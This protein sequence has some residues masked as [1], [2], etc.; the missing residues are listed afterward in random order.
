M[1]SIFPTSSGISSFYHRISSDRGLATSVLATIGLIAKASITSLY[2][3]SFNPIETLAAGSALALS[4]SL[5][6]R[7]Q[8]KSK[9]QISSSKTTS[10]N[11]P[12]T[13]TENSLPAKPTPPP[14]A[15]RRSR[16]SSND[17]SQPDTLRRRPSSAKPTPPPVVPRKPEPNP[18]NTGLPDDIT[19]SSPPAKPMANDPA[20]EASGATDPEVRSPSVKDLLSH[21]EE[22]SSPPESSINPSQYQSSLSKAS[23]VNTFKRDLNNVLSLRKENIQNALLIF[24]KDLREHKIKY[25][26]E[27]GLFTGD[28]RMLESLKNV[29][30]TLKFLGG[31]SYASPNSGVF[32]AAELYPLTE[33]RQFLIA[34][35]H[36][37]SEHDSF[38]RFEETDMTKKDQRDSYYEAA[39]SNFEET[40][41]RL[42][43]ESRTHLSLEYLQIISSKINGIGNNV[44][45]ESYFPAL[46]DLFYKNITKFL[47]Q[48]VI[49]ARL[50]YFVS[51]PEYRALFR[52]TRFHLTDKHIKNL[53]TI[54]P[55]FG[56]STLQLVINR[57]NNKLKSIPALR[58]DD[59]DKLEKVIRKL[60]YL[61]PASDDEVAR[62]FSYAKSNLEKSLLRGS[63]LKDCLEERSDLDYVDCVAQGLETASKGYHP[64]EKS[65]LNWIR[66][67]LRLINPETMWNQGSN[68]LIHKGICFT[69]SMERLAKLLKNPDA[70]F[71]DHESLEVVVRQDR[72][73][74]DW[75]VVREGNHGDSLK[76]KEYKEKYYQGKGLNSSDLKHFE[77]FDLNFKQVRDNFF[78]TISKRKML[79]Q[80]HIWFSDESGHAVNYQWD[81]ELDI[82]RFIDD[83]FGE[84][85]VCKEEFDQVFIDYINAFYKVAFKITKVELVTD[86]FVWA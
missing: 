2:Y 30:A 26:T 53:C 23:V 78:Q 22:A 14:V 28:D 47:I 55:Y 66:K 19:A 13:I 15:P 40:Y 34:L 16:L 73:A 83:N 85:R 11:R 6:G 44:E 69:G 61:N 71:E 25:W 72:V 52:F 7:V 37:S 8:D 20:Q 39:V 56:S 38:D 63:K 10:P 46:D 59:Q 12:S 32:N 79:A 51:S 60:S 35:S 74:L 64:S 3:R 27:K 54:I 84:V 29:L 33:E 65:M 18:T 42:A 62:G 45:P 58:P 70:S 43:R 80:V 24:V 77:V 86:N 75:R 48:K 1:P 9:E 76:A 57:L 36:P 82:Y 21:L 41:G 17:P 81:E 50:N 68:E 4:L 49:E 5:Y 31:D 67:N